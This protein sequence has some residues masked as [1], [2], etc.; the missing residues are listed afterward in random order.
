MIRILLV[1]DHP[2]VRQGLIA[3]LQAAPDC[4]VIGE[5]SD[6][7][8][9]L[10]KARKE[11]PDLILLDISL[12]GR[13]G[14]EV[15]K[16]LHIEQPLTK[17]LVLSTFSEKQYAVRCLKMGAQGYLTKKSA[18]GE[19][20][21]AIEKVIA[22]GKYV[23]ASLADHLAA[24]IGPEVTTVP[25]ERLSDRE[26]QVLCLLGQGRTVTQISQ[27]LSISVSAVNKYRAQILHKMNLGTT[28]QLIRYA[29]DNDLA[30]PTE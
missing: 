5:A 25:H 19:L 28:A 2:I 27:D 23:S 11:K 14:L 24:E 6:G 10:L 30:N 8:D 17:V 16:Q 9:A 29:L 4:W 26:F 21:N 1:D 20:L 3:V 7:D 12:P 18:S 13:S 22:G 15:L